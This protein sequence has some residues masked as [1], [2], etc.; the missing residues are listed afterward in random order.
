LPSSIPALEHATASSLAPEHATAST[1][2]SEHAVVILF[3][4]LLVIVTLPPSTST[5]PPSKHA[6][7][8][9]L[10]PTFL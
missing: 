1:L 3:L 9:D 2:A 6:T 10:D 7:A 8:V 5:L 4:K